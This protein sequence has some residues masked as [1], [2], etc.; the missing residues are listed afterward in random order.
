VSCFRFNSS[1]SDWDSAP[2]RDSDSDSDSDKQKKKKLKH[3]WEEVDDS[4]EVGFWV[5]IFDRQSILVARITKQPYPWDKNDTILRYC[6]FCNVLR[7]QDRGTIFYMS[8][9]VPEGDI[10]TKGHL[11]DFMMRT[12]E[13]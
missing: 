12:G 7:Y 3:A 5:W 9:V 10:R 1:G 4:N 8:D 11:G 13:F 6:H 2:A